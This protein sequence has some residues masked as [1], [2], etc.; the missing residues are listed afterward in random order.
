MH[1]IEQSEED[2]R[3]TFPLGQSEQRETS[4][5]CSVALL[6]LDLY[7][8]WFSL[9]LF[10]PI[11]SVYAESLG[12]SMS[13]VGLIIG[14]YGFT[15]LFI[16][17][18]LGMWSDRLG[19]RKPFVTVAFVVIALSLLGL[20]QAPNPMWLVASR[21]F[22]GVAAAIW[23]IFSVLYSSYFP[24]HRSVKA[25]G[26]ATF[27]QGAGMVMATTAGGILADAYGWRST[28]YLA[29]VPAVL[30]AV[31][32]LFVA[33]DKSVREPRVFSLSELSR[34]QGVRLLVIA[35]VLASVIQ[36]VNYT[37]T[38]SFVP[39]YGADLG[40]SRTVLGWLST[41]VLLPYT[42]SAL[43]AS[44][45]VDRLGERS[46]VIL[47]LA[48]M[49]VTS[50]GIPYIHDVTLLLVSRVIYG[51]GSGLAFPVLMGL[52]IKE[53]AREQRASA[54]GFFQAVYAVGMFAGPTFSGFMADAMGIRGM[55]QVVGL[56][57]LGTLVA[58]I[59]A[60]PGE[61]R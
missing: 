31:L 30:G 44:R 60:I 51:V 5:T 54:M 59:W 11:L 49:V 42:L 7:L 15:Q 32:S 29:L 19:R 6:S 46:L 53:I 12:A 58:A 16:R 20:A 61:R 36:Y 8:Y 45:L 48:L 22:T 50:G 34:M 52:A 27:F 17:I 39:I 1:S 4:R 38:F 3:M 37:T 28:F 47:G 9:Y 40:A 56:I 13:M 57:S 41:A 14:S 21:A 55:F 43:A 2:E 35:S 33:D 24:R 25:M 18:P 26:L 23:V 10:V